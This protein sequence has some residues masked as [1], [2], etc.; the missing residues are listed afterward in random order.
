MLMDWVGCAQ[1]VVDVLTNVVLDWSWSVWSA[2]IGAGLSVL[3][4]V[5][6]WGGSVSFSCSLGDTCKCC[7]V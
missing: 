7:A 5:L 1:F 2:L 6:D 4:F 3:G